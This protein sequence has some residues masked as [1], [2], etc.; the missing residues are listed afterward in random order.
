MAKNQVSKEENIAMWRSWM[1]SVEDQELKN[2]WNIG[3]CQLSRKQLASAIGFKGV[4]PLRQNAT[5]KDELALFEDEL[6]NRAGFEKKTGSATTASSKQL[7]NAP[8]ASD[9]NRTKVAALEKRVVE[10]E[11]EVIKL[12]AENQQYAEIKATISEMGGRY[13]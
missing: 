3:R 7:D 6:R 10:L 1:T 2:M 12:K 8:T 4:E 5:I 11:Q 13:L 9:K